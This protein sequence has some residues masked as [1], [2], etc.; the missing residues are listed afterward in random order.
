MRVVYQVFL[1]F[2][3]VCMYVCMYVESMLGTYAVCKLCCWVDGRLSVGGG[4]S[5]VAWGVVHLLYQ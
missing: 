2:S 4:G 3:P 1:Q 5:L